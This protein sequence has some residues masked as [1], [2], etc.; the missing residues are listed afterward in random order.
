[1]R[2]RNESVKP[3]MTLRSGQ[4]I[5]RFFGQLDLVDPGVVSCPLWRPDP[6]EIGPPRAVEEFCGVARKP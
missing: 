5:A 3:V 2:L 6:A 4:Q 1:M